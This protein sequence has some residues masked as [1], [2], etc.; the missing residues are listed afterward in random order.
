MHKNFHTKLYLLLIFFAIN[1]LSCTNSMKQTII[2][3]TKSLIDKS[4]YF[5]LRNSDSSYYYAKKAYKLAKKYK[6]KKQQARALIM[7]AKR[8]TNEEKFHEAINMLEDAMKLAEKINNDTIYD[9]A[10][11]E[12]VRTIK[13]LG[14]ENKV[15]EKRIK[16]FYVRQK[17]KSHLHNE[18]IIQKIFNDYVWNETQLPK[19]FKNFIWNNLSI[20]D[21]IKDNM[22]DDINKDEYNSIILEINKII[23]SSNIDNDTAM[24]NKA[25]AFYAKAKI[26][27]KIDTTYQLIIKCYTE[28]IKYDKK[29]N[30]K[31]AWSI[32]TLS[33]YYLDLYNKDNKISFLVKSKQYND[34]ANTNIR[35]FD[36]IYHYQRKEIYK[37]YY[38]Y[39]LYMAKIDSTKN[40][41]DSAITYINN[42]NSIKDIIFKQNINY[43]EQII[44]KEQTLFYSQR[45]NIYFVIIIFIIILS[46]LFVLF[47]YLVKKYKKDLKKRNKE[48]EER[49]KEI[50]KRNKKIQDL[51]NELNSNKE[52]K[53]ELMKKMQKLYS[54]AAREGVTSAKLEKIIFEL[55]EKEK[56]IQ[57]IT[58]KINDYD[59]ILIFN[60]LKQI[61]NVGL[62]KKNEIIEK[63]REINQRLIINYLYDYT[64]KI[65]GEAFTF[66][67][68]E[69]MILEKYYS[70]IVEDDIASIIGES[71]SKT[72][73]R[74]RSLRDK[75]KNLIEQGKMD[76][77]IKEHEL[78][79]NNIKQ[80]INKFFELI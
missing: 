49:K 28:S 77:F 70:Y 35:Q 29:L 23:A 8:K 17:K 44:E 31:Q 62:K 18:I 15:Y 63:I 76:D 60:M 55:L 58:T 3:E 64:I 50:E 52:A 34:T 21:F 37:N 9:L 2:A 56:L 71:K 22:W 10:L 30:N 69:I 7:L 61:K 12:Q 20:Q 78:N 68:R 13:F 24:H 57:E 72:K 1:S 67:M 41:F 47:L 36:R 6:L 53:T 40:Y 80:I 79:K 19:N 27:I 16:D 54:I 14:L 73:G 32:F 43:L 38:M 51:T 46:A 26:Y 65:T 74:R 42:V 39:Y 66:I 45:L 4:I 11:S 75:I 5:E 48:I 59:I 25:K 33:S